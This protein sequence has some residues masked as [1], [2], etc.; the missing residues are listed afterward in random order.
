MRKDRID[1]PRY[2][3]HIRIVR[4]NPSA[5][6]GSDPNDPFSDPVEPGQETY[7]VVYDGI[8][9]SFTDTT[10]TGTDDV[11]TNKRKASIPVRFDKW[12]V[13]VR[14]LDGD[15]IYAT[16]GNNTEIGQVR[17]FEPDNN[18][19]LVYWDFVRV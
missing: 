14:P 3:H 5:G 10:T 18:R 2:P 17:D 8:G 11:D 7:V 9:R 15:T 1:N 6:E 16:V 13:G 19:S 4:V 12:E